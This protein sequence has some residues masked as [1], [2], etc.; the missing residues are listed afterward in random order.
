MFLLLCV[1]S[2]QS[3]FFVQTNEFRTFA[4]EQLCD[5]ETDSCFWRDDS[6]AWKWQRKK[7]DSNNPPVIDHRGGN[8]SKFFN[9][10]EMNT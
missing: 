2:F 9:K 8:D 4:P 1:L 7:I 6:I 10:V 3:I 5:F